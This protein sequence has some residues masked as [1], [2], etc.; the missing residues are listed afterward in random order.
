MGWEGLGAF[1]EFEIF[2]I[3]GGLHQV[4]NFLN[5]SQIEKCML[6][7]Y[8]YCNHLKRFIMQ[9]DT[10]EMLIL[11]NAWKKS[12]MSIKDTYE[13]FD[14]VDYVWCESFFMEKSDIISNSTNGDIYL[15]S[16]FTWPQ[17]VSNENEETEV[18]PQ[19]VEFS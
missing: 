6:Q 13:Y 10:I 4:W 8:C 7:I 16:P 18:E 14:V 3:R 9:G 19:V 15:K 17:R 2:E 12:K 5:S 11:L 1:V